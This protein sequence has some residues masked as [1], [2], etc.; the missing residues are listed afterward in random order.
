[1]TPI[2]TAI[3]L[4]VGIVLV[5]LI[6]LGLLLLKRPKVDVRVHPE[7]LSEERRAAQTRRL[8]S[9]AGTKYQTHEDAYTRSGHSRNA[10]LKAT[11]R[12]QG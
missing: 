8:R 4:E 1:M 11:R 6:A 2:T 7:L 10:D 12:G 3:W 9:I 5:A